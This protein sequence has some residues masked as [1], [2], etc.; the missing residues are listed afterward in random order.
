MAVPSQKMPSSSVQRKRAGFSEEL[1]AD[2]LIDA[3]NQKHALAFQFNFVRISI[4]GSPSKSLQRESHRM[5]GP[6][7]EGQCSQILITRSPVMAPAHRPHCRRRK[8]RVPP[9]WPAPDTRKLSSVTDFIKKESLLWRVSPKGLGSGHICIGTS[10]MRARPMQ[11][12]MHPVR[13]CPCHALS[14]KL[15]HMSRISSWSLV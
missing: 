12:S 11:D 14:R 10:D 6:V 3:K 4:V 13:D 7:F 9:H 8:A 1:K 2:M 5:S 15:L